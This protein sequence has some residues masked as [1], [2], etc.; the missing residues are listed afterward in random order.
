[1]QLNELKQAAKRLRTLSPEQGGPATPLSHAQ[2]LDVVAQ[3]HGF[4]HYHEAR[5]RLGDPSDSGET[6]T[7]TTSP[8]AAG[9]PLAVQKAMEVMAEA[10]GLIPVSGNIADLAAVTWPENG[11]MVICGLPGSGKTILAREIV[12]RALATGT[13]VRIL[14]TEGTYRHFAYALGGKHYY[15]MLDPGAIDAWNSEAPF[16][17]I[18]LSSSLA[19]FSYEALRG[20]PSHALF[21]CEDPMYQGLPYKSLGGRTLRIMTTYGMVEASDVQADVVFTQKQGFRTV[22]LIGAPGTNTV[23][24]RHTLSCLRNERYFGR[25]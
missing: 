3:L 19:G 4:R 2:A 5:Q 21:V 16:V 7:S 14:D 13:P 25:V 22:W 17:V 11:T 9:M 23:E 24:L 8:A 10:G 20:L 1:M 15:D 18:S 12:C 6:L